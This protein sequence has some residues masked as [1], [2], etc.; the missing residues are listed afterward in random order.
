MGLHSLRD[1]LFGRPQKV[2]ELGHKLE[3]GELIFDIWER[4]REEVDR[5]SWRS[6]WQALTVDTMHV[7][8]LVVAIL[9]FVFSVV[10]DEI[11]WW[12][13]PWNSSA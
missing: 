7:G 4:L 10:L 9:D 2:M 3:H 1:V 5:A 6:A 11:E 13:V 12:L 8:L